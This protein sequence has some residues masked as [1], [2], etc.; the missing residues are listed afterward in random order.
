MINWIIG[1]IIIAVTILIVVRS[2]IRLK[3][4][5]GGCNCAECDAVHCNYSGK[6]P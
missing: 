6:K 1:G 4:G 2:F 3:S 5:K